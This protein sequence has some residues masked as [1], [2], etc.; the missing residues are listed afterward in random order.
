MLDFMAS[1]KRS[2]GK[3]H[4]RNDEWKLGDLMKRFRFCLVLLLG[5]SFSGDAGAAS[6]NGV[7]MSMLKGSC[8]KLVIGKDN[9]T[10]DC[11]GDL[12]STAYQDRRVGFY[13]LTRRNQAFTFSGLDG[14]SPT[15][16]ADV[17]NIDKVVINLDGKEDTARS[18]H[19]TGQCIYGNGFTGD[20]MTIVCSG[21]IKGGVKFSAIFTTD[22][23]PPR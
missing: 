21:T 19:A 9:Y 18:Y 22:G 12:M 8:D 23:S 3:C 11:T 13:F 4:D 15:K 2:S 7:E 16:D 10:A 17:T 5:G 1:N 20:P 6:F 14:E